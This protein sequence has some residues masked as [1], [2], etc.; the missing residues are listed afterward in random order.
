LL[1][2]TDARVLIFSIGRALPVLT[3]D[4]DDFEDLHECPRTSPS[5]VKEN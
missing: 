4:A 2:V 5:L 1:S 3:R